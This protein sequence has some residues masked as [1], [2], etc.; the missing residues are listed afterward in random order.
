MNTVIHYEDSV[1]N[2]I[3][4]AFLLKFE[5]EWNIIMT[6]FGLSQKQLLL[7]SRLRPQLTL[8]GYLATTSLENKPDLRLI[9]Q[10]AISVEMIHK[11][12]LLIDDWI[13]GDI[14]RHGEKTFHIE[15]GPQYTVVMAIFIVS[16]S[17]KRLSEILPQ[18][19]VSPTCHHMCVDIIA[20]TV[21]SMSFGLLQE[22]ELT[23]ISILDSKKIK[24]IAHLETA[25][26]LGNGMLLGYFVGG[27][28]DDSLSA[29]FKTI[30]DQCGYLF[31]T[32]NDLEAFKNKEKNQSHKGL[33][34]YDIDGKRKNIAVAKLYEV[35]LKKDRLKIE[36]GNG[37]EIAKLIVKYRITDMIL[38]EMALVFNQI[39]LST[40]SFIT[41]GVSK[42][43]VNGFSAFMKKLKMIAEQRLAE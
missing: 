24:E 22:L 36:Q 7:G 28:A 30:G 35:A 15:Y 37:S 11:A 32:M 40:K 18:Y 8:W 12:S 16:E 6:S 17:M 27:G 4:D 19:M 39:L 33:I 2:N 29:L 34:N 13:D 38:N 9:S 21:H 10:T 31:Q 41:Y 1:F 43:W 25:E 42:D 23:D 20:K 14:A 26:I 3:A 5:M